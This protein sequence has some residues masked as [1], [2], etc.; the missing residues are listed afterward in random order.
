L[1]APVTMIRLPLRLPSRV[2][3]Q[4]DVTS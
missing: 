2:D 3:D 4:F 1:V